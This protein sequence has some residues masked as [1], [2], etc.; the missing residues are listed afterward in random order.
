MPEM[1]SS[2]DSAVPACK[3][4]RQLDVGTAV[5]E[6]MGTLVGFA[7]YAR[8]DEATRRVFP[9][10]EPSYRAKITLPGSV[11]DG[12][13]LNVFHLTT[14][15][16]EG[17]EKSK[18]P[19]LHGYLQ[20]VA[21]SNLQQRS[22]MAMLNYHA[23]LRNCAVVGT[24]NKNE[25]DQGF[26]V[27]WCDGGYDVAPIRHLFKTQVYELAEHLDLPVEI[28]QATPTTAHTAPTARRRSLFSGCRSR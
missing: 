6:M 10:Y 18:R 17:E 19:K 27:K 5:E 28:R 7:C 14:I 3:I 22:R 9:E 8:R 11:L 21:A 12:D 2:R 13:A 24:P 15:S 20:I 26:S 25:H 16:P 23:E 1:D 4:A